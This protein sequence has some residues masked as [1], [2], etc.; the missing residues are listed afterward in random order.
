MECITSPQAFC[1]GPPTS[2]CIPSI[3]FEAGIPFLLQSF[4]S[5]P[6]ARYFANPEQLWDRIQIPVFLHSLS[7]S[8]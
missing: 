1:L 7:V 3:L 5:I 4:H 6:P 8:P 2:Q